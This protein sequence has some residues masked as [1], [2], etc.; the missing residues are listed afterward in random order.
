M[1]CQLL[2]RTVA[3]LIM[4]SA[5]SALNSSMAF[6]DSAAVCCLVSLFGDLGVSCCP[7][8]I[9]AEIKT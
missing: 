6:D 1:E 7:N 8:A 3:S 2:F 5:A 9:Q 4:Y